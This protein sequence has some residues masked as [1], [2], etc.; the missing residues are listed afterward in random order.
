MPCTSAVS[1]VINPPLN[2]IWPI[3]TPASARMA[4]DVGGASGAPVDVVRATSPSRLMNESGVKRMVASSVEIGMSVRRLSESSVGHAV[5]SLRSVN[6]SMASGPLSH[7][8]RNDGELVA[9]CVENTRR[10]SVPLNRI[11]QRENPP[12]AT[13]CASEFTESTDVGAAA[14]AVSVTGTGVTAVEPIGLELRND[15]E[16][17]TSC[18]Q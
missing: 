7:D 1:R 8:A 15:C 6:T 16:L 14:T 5:G 4:S 12:A 10:R 3:R 18:A 17:A 11:P 13:Y 2:H 9:P